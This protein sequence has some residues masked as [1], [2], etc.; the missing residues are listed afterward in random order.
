M[1]A[2]LF[3]A[4]FAGSWTC[5][6]TQYR[7]PWSIAQ[8]AGKS[9]WS[10]VRYGPPDAPGGT[11]YVGPLPQEHGYIYEDFHVDGS[12]ARLSSPGPVNNVWTWTGTY[13]PHGGAADSTPYITWTLVKGTIERRF[14]QKLPQGIVERGTDTCT[15]A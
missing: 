14:A 10:V 7:A 2:D 13:F 6:N 11:A 8:A 4:A 3:L 9:A 5:G 15:R 1:I 12:Y